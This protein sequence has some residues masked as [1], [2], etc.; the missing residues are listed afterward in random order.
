MKQKQN[1]K[2][3][4]ADDPNFDAN[5]YYGFCEDSVEEEHDHSASDF[6]DRLIK[7]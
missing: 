4:D 1:K 6:E 3:K 7:E 2:R 5:E